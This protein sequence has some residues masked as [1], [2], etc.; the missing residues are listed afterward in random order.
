[1]KNLYK[2]LAN[3]QREV[4]SIHKNTQGYGYKYADLS[5]IIETINPLLEKHNLGFSQPLNGNCVDTIIFHIDTGDSIKSSVEIPSGVK[6]KGMNDFQVLGSAITYLR[7]YSLGSVLGLITDDDIDAAGEQIKD[8][9]KWLNPNTI[10]WKN[11][12]SKKVSIDVIK[13]HYKISK[14]NEFKFLNETT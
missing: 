12:V 4:K 10:D 8:D 13:Q 11:A 3:F 6:M 2:S 7:R 9:K 14:E 5:V 1:M